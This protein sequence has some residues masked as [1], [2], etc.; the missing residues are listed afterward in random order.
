M[1]GIGHY[2]L[3]FPILCRKGEGGAG[4]RRILRQDFLKD[5]ILWR[6][7]AS[8][9]TGTAKEMLHL[10]TQSRIESSKKLLTKGGY[11]CNL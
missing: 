3:F 1:I 5:P 7:P 10:R 2:L 6:V 11:A 4:D 8:A 9:E